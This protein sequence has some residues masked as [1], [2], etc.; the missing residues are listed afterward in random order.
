MLGFH[1]TGPGIN[2]HTPLSQQDNYA[3]NT[4]WKIRLRPGT[5]VYRLVGLYAGS[6]KPGSGSFQVP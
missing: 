1:L 5:Y 3:T 4:S 6:Y 2:R